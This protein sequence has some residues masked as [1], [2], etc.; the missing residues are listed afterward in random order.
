[1]IKVQNRWWMW[2]G[3]ADLGFWGALRT[4]SV[5]VVNDKI[6]GEY[7]YGVDLKTDS[8]TYV[9]TPKDG[10]RRKAVF[11]NLGK[12]GFEL[13]GAKYTKAT[14]AADG[15]SVTLELENTQGDGAYTPTVD[16]TNLPES[17]WKVSVAGSG[18][19]S[20]AT[21]DVARAD[22]GS[23]TVPLSLEGSTATVTISTGDPDPSP[24]PDDGS[25]DG[26]DKADAGTGK[27]TPLSATGSDVTGLLIVALAFIVI[28]T[29]VLIRSRRD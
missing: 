21:A 18:S 16:L 5:N 4:A 14:V 20:D 27:S 26:S 23:A 29:T 22:D 2:S 17:E 28:G 25:G 12:L 11:Y 15:K 8:G 19:G 1:M 13:S 10:V 3:E 9:I 7:A 6:L 24:N